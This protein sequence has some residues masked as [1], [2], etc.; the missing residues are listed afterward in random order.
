MAESPAPATIRFEDIAQ[1]A[2]V[3]FVTQNFPTPNKNQIE[4]MVAGVALFDYD[5]D[6]YLDIYFVN[7]AEIPS[8]KKTSPEYW[9][10]LYHNNHDG[11][12]TDVTEKAGRR[13]C[14]LRNGCGGR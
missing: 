5:G 3:H 14:G 7:G 1:K 4:T 10:R 2:G 6:G 9:N 12:F 13:G 11:T 8:L